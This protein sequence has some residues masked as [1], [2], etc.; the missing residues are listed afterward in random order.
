MKKKNIKYNKFIEIMGEEVRIEEELSKYTTFKIGGKADLFCLVKSE[1]ILIRAVKVADELEIP[2]VVMGSGSNILVSDEGYRG[3]VIKNENKEKIE[4]FDENKIFV[5]SGVSLSEL[6]EFSADNSLAGLDL[7]AGI[8]GSV[9]GAVYMNAGAFGCIIGEHI[10]SGKVIDKSG[11]LY[12]LNKG[13]FS[14]GYRSS[15]LQKSGEILVSIVLKL[16]KGE[17]EKIYNKI[18]EIIEIRRKKHP[19]KT[20][21]C[22][23]SYFKNIIISGQMEKREPAGFYLEKAGLKGMQCGG[24][25]VFE[26]HANFI[27]NT[28]EAKS[29]DVLKLARIMKDKV[30]KLFGI[31]LNEEVVYLDDIKGFSKL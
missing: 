8:P 18:N 4:I 2:F 29:S 22:A 16:I 20:V 6:L 26:K 10:L 31:E 3:L 24:A 23:G 13:E 14:F 30:K 19:D 25:K 7:L 1:D 28:G 12:E 21:P 11:N 9:G 5:N 27:I 17:K 15:R